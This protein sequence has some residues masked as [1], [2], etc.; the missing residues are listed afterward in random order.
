MFG[1]VD[2]IDGYV[3]TVNELF[4]DNRLEVSS[5]RTSNDLLYFSFIICSFNL[6][7]AK[8]GLVVF[9]GD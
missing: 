1:T 9:Y 7:D 8:I 4:F 3:V 2:V 6:I 5:S